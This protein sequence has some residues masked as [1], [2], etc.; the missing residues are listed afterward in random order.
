M[1]PHHKVIFSYRYFGFC[2]VLFTLS[3]DRFECFHETIEYLICNVH[4]A[5][6][7]STLKNIKFDNDINHLNVYLK[8]I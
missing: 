6:R 8:N 2:K 3:I 5:N 1:Y 7:I 4:T